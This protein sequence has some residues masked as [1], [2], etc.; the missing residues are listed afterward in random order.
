M[1]GFSYSS[2]EISQQS[3]NRIPGDINQDGITN[4]QDIIITVNLIFNGEY[5]EL[6][7]L[8]N[9]EIVNV[10]DI[11]EIINIIL[12]GWIS[13]YPENVLF[14]GNSYTYFNGGVNNH[15]DSFVGEA[16]PD[17]EFYTSA[18]T[19]GGATLQSHFST[20]N[21]INTI[22]TGN[23][24]YVILQEQ[25]TRP[26]DNPELF[27]QYAELMDEVITNSGAETMFFMTWAR[28]SNPEMIEGLEEAYNLIGNQ[29]NAYV[30]PVGRAWQ[31]ALD[32]NHQI[33]LYSNDG[34]HPNVKGTY[35]TV[36]MFYTCLFGES[37]EGIEFINDP[38]ITTE[39]QI[40]LQS[41]A[42]QTYLQD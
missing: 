26:V 12:Y 14:I 20:A 18:I 17:I 32:Q 10:I 13:P 7:D 11:L 31:M 42:W 28:A 35:L 41:I 23:W 37:P 9:D 19:M 29:L 36:C 33:D 24:D 4:I 6:A 21:T 3:F 39:E 25:S 2:N 16:L 38:S 22:E 34:S 8:N 40:F 1:F 5:N 27:Y 15:L 30:C